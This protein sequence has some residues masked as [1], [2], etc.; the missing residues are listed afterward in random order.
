LPDCFNCPALV[1]CG[2]AEIEIDQWMLVVGAHL[3]M[4][5]GL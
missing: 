2:L 1:V 4:D 3:I 5:P